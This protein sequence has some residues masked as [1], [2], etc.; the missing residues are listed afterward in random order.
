LTNFATLTRMR[1]QLTLRN[2]MFF[3][4]SVIIPFGFFFLYAGVF[5]RG[6]P[7]VVRYFLGP[8]LALT[9]MG[10]F[11]GSAPLSS[12]SGTGHPAPLPRYS[13]NPERHACFQ[14]RRQLRAYDTYCSHRIPVCPHHLSRDPF[15]RPCL[16]I[17]PYYDRYGVLASMGLVV[18]SVTN[19]MQETQVINQLIWLPLIFLSG[20]TVPLASLPQVV[21]HVGLFFPPLISSLASK[22]LSTGPLLP[23]VRMFCSGSARSPSGRPQFFLSA[24]LFRWSPS[25][26]FPAEPSCSPPPPQSP[27]SFWGFGKTIP[28]GPYRWRKRCMIRSMLREAGRS[29]N[30]DAQFHFCS[31]SSRRSMASRRDDARQIG[32]ENGVS[33]TLDALTPYP[34]VPYS[35]IRATPLRGALSNREHL[36][37]FRRPRKSGTT[38]VDQLGRRQVARPFSRGELR[39]LG[40]RRHPLL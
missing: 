33:I 8:V 23:G 25:P 27:F 38:E 34:S 4:F 29:R 36:C 14:R 1:I 9:V 15:R 40:F 17:S 39:L 21:K 10:S 30:H 3:F 6:I 32:S 5:A 16:G 37:R 26:R 11:W 20:A 7:L 22:A 31:L 2:K 18:A 24:Q 13:R 28:T 35:A 12:V 19:T